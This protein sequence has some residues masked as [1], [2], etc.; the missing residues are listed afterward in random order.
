MKN[1]FRFWMPAELKKAVDPKTN[2]EKIYLAGFA[3][4]RRKD[5]DGESLNQNFDISYLT[6]RGIINWNHSKDPDCVIGEPDEV[7]FVNGNLWVKSMLYEDQKMAQKVA[8][9]AKVFSKNS[10]KRKLGYSIEGKVIERDENDPEIVN[11]A[12]ITNIAVT[13]NPKNCD[14]LIDLVKGSF[15]GW[16]DEDERPKNEVID[17]DDI[18]LKAETGDKENFIIDIQKPDGT[19]VR[20]DE[21][22]NV[23]VK[24]LDTEKGKVLKSESVD[25]KI[26]DVTT[27]K[28]K[29]TN[30][31]EEYEVEDDEE[32]DEEE[33]DDNKDG[34]TKG[35]V[36]HK[37]IS[38]NSGISLIKAN[39][40]FEKLNE[41]AMSNKRTAITED[42]LNKSLDVLGIVESESE[43]QNEEA[44]ETEDSGYEENINKGEDSE[45]LDLDDVPGIEDSEGFVTREEFKKGMDDL[46]NLIRSAGVI[47]KHNY[48][49]TK[50]LQDEL[51]V[52]SNRVNGKVPPRKAIHSQFDARPVQR[53]F[54]KAIQGES[55]DDQRNSLSISQNKQ[56]VL[57]MM[58]SITFK[59][60]TVD[61]QMSKAM[62]TF[63]STGNI[64]SDEIKKSIENEFNVV[65]VR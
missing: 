27:N 64:Y 18:L 50:S 57:E 26:K 34:L 52:L 49:I 15:T 17:I 5:I 38:Y 63:E 59:N 65:L 46:A 19:V 25:G 40:I 12:L 22:F 45:E 32:D 31:K 7:K 56:K 13:V 10:S 53:E 54:N 43:G 60:N 37:I 35:E 61:Q 36:I 33:N 58:D 55:F 48:D 11:K 42:L 4:S 41:K 20:V 39:E 30:K 21:D 9:L 28:N 23:L 14:S 6:E 2:S 62:T 29:I 3:S 47:S 51:L 16:E 1:N 8:N 24:S 44:A